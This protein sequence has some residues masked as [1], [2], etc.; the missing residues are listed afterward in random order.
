MLAVKKTCLTTDSIKIDGCYGGGCECKVYDTT[1]NAIVFKL[2]NEY[3][4]YTYNKVAR[5]VEL[6]RKFAGRG[7]APQVY[8]DV[9]KLDGQFGYF[10]E[11]II[12]APQTNLSKSKRIDYEN[13]L[14]DGLEL[15]KDNSYE[16][17]HNW[18]LTKDKKPVLF[19]FGLLTL[20][21]LG[22]IESNELRN[23]ND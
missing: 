19:D 10:T 1:N 23:S 16:L 22:I 9:V 15:G 18:G 20:W 2:Y 5:I 21:L 4:N 17:S 7:L 11:R 12:P 3:E 8:G 6:N 14:L 13:D